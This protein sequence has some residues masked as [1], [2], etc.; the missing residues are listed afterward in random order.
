MNEAIDEMSSLFILDVV[1]GAT[2]VNLC[3]RAIDYYIAAFVWSL[4][5]IQ[6]RIKKDD[7]GTIGEY[8]KEFEEVYERIRPLVMQR[9]DYADGVLM[10]A[11]RN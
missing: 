3:D 4:I 6:V 2:V 7:Q 10:S 11:E 8:R 9:L 1:E 5:S